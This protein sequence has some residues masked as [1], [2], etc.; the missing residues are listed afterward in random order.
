[1]ACSFLC[2]WKMRSHI[3]LKKAFSEGKEMAVSL[4]A[5]E[6]HKELSCY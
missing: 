5:A 6:I 1:M 3:N 4:G 2:Y